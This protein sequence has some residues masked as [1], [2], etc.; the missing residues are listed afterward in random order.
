MSNPLKIL[1]VEDD[2]DILEVAK[3][4]LEM[5]GG[6]NVLQCS[7]GSNALAR[8][9]DFAPDLFLL[10]MM[11]PEMSGEQL[12][13]KL[14]EDPQFDDIPVIFMT[15]RAQASEVDALKG[16]GAVDVIVKPFDPVTLSD[17]IN[18]VMS[19]FRQSQL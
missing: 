12:L 19:K 5:V 7:S 2:A 3:L 17:Q 18:Q 6:F 11:M 4:A 14:R 9:A 16:L 8:A 1:H 13:T 15:A 10:D